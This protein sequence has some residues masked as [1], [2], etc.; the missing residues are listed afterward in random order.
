MNNNT[1]RQI[2]ERIHRHKEIIAHLQ[3]Q[4][5][6]HPELFMRTIARHKRD[7]TELQSKL[8]KLTQ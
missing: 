6:M 8:K 3:A 5:R 7:I 2:Y 4:S 1:T